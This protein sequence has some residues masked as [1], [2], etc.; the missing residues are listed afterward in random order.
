MTR[1]IT[2]AITVMT[3]VLSLWFPTR[4]Q[5]TLSGEVAVTAQKAGQQKGYLIA[6]FTVNDSVTFQKYRN[7]AAGLAQKYQGK[8]IMRD[9]NSKTVEGDA[10]REITA[11]IE[12]PSFDHAEGY[13]NSPEY[14]A[15]R[16]FGIAAAERLVILAKGIFPENEPK[17]SGQ[18]KGY[19]VANFTIQDQDTFKKYIESGGSLVGKFNGNTLIYD[20]DAKTVEGNGEHIIAVMEFA[21]FADL[22][23]FYNSPEYT[24]ARK[25]RIAATK[26]S[27][28][29]GEG[30]RENPKAK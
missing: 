27:V 15:A 5:E 13:Y 14:T 6:N 26:G 29:L 20:V 30:I 4:A 7:A 24:A 11:I 25:F 21:S 23:R 28:V 1:Q 17:D 3:I 2:R 12:F 16:V 18:A 22:D 8:M 9:V 19:L 10:P